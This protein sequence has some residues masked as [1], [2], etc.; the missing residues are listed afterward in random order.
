MNRYG[1]GKG[2]RAHRRYTEI[3]TSEVE[4]FQMM[5]R[6]WKWV[7]EIEVTVGE[8]KTTSNSEARV[9]RSCLHRHG[10]FWYYGRT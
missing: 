5:T 4:W 6:S 10:S 2:E 9:W 3:K 7:A 8:L 1:G